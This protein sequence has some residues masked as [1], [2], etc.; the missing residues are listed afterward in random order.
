[1]YI[2][3]RPGGNDGCRGSRPASARGNVMKGIATF[4]MTVAVVL[5]MLSVCIVASGSD[6][7]AIIEEDGSG[8]CGDNIR[9]TYTY[10]TYTLTISGSGAMYDYKESPWEYSDYGFGC[11][12]VNKVIFQGSITHIGNYAL[13]QTRISSVEMCDSI[14]SIGDYA[15]ANCDRLTTI[16]I[17]SSVESVGEY[18]F[19]DDDALT[20]VVFESDAVTFGGRAFA[21]CTALSSINI[22]DGTTTISTYMFWSCSSLK[23]LKMPT[24]LE[25]IEYAAFY[26]CSTNVNFAGCNNVT[27]IDGISGNNVSSF[28]IPDS[29]KDVKLG[30]WD[31]LTSLTLGTGVESITF[32]GTYENLS[33]ISVK[34]GNTNFKSVGNVLYSY[35]GTQL[36]YYPQGLTATTLT[37]AS[38]VSTIG[39]VSNDNLRVVNIPSTV[40]SVNSI[41]SEN[42]E[43]LC[44]PSNIESFTYTEPS[45]LMIVPTSFHRSDA[46]SSG[47]IIKYQSQIVEGVTVTESGYNIILNVDFTDGSTFNS[48]NLGTEFN[49]TDV[50]SSTSATLTLSSSY[51]YYPKIYMSVDSSLGAEEL[52]EYTPSSGGS[53]L[54]TILQ[55]AAALIVVALIIFG[56]I[57]GGA[58]YIIVIR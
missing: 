46:L 28:T 19:Y 2:P 51:S 43:I 36:V 9:W 44:V 41:I 12:Y 21:G 1:M 20:S 3:I 49:G 48:I 32:G 14:V 24:S 23:S 31:S 29:V 47:T 53:W 33:T 16:T 35:D 8:T 54:D 10:S 40:T 7:D 18:A 11:Y 56:L 55:R 50:Q 52:N 42:L 4:G 34:S 15:F 38:G 58:Y 27:N 39:T 45:V 13:N 25:T 57:G 30:F 37:V 6:S 17:S 26:R 22:P 5:A